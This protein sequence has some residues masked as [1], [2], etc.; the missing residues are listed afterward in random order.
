MVVS[1]NFKR[2]GADTCV[3]TDSCLLER[4]IHSPLLTH[5]DFATCN[6]DA[7]VSPH[8]I[9]GNFLLFTCFE[10]G[11]CNNRREMFV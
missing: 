7:R 3:K 5:R 4:V 10:E 8:N 11:L 2:V 6:P 1:C 9:S